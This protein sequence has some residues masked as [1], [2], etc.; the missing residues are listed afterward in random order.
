[1][2]RLVAGFLLACAAL[3]AQILVDAARIPAGLRS[4]QPLPGEQPARCELT[5]LRPMLNFGFR[6]QAG[7]VA[8]LP[9]NQYLG[10]GHKM[11]ILAR[12]TPE[13]GDRKP[14]YLLQT[15][16]LPPIP[17][18]N[19]EGEVG[20]GYLLGEGRYSVSWM[21]L[22]DANRVCR[23]EWRIDVQLNHSE[24]KVRPAMPPFTVSDFSPR[25]SA[26]S[27]SDRD[28]ARPVRLTVLLHAAPLSPRRTQLRA[29]DRMMLLGSLASLL[30][31]V[32]ARWVRLV[33]F[34]LDQQK[35]IYRKDRFV[36]QELEQ[37]AQS[38]NDL[39]LGMVDYGVL[40]NRRGHI[41]LL[42]NLVHRELTAAE[43]SEAVVFLGPTARFA[44]KPPKT[45][46][47]K[48]AAATPRFFYFQFKP[49]FRRSTNSF[50]DSIN[51][52][53]DRLKGKN[54]VIHSPGEFAKAIE[55]LESRVA[56]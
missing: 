34:S 39:E 23:K 50:P 13:G 21:L 47:E 30:E 11:A 48:P 28:D 53:V 41:D 22:D 2:R 14:V 26:W 46:L 44:D 4:L 40:Q 56:R 55:D 3:S 51:F 10:S 49:L 8:R 20:G 7:Y 24:S 45:V 33:V 27:R 9:L 32:P 38:L 36:P 52:A 1:M 15:L 35:E 18:T 17:K 25:A 43:P 37:V 16:K 5:P 54:L 29:G 19:Q 31:R 6:F 12:I 42:A